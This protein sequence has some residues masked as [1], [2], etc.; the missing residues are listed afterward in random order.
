MA[1]CIHVSYISEKN[2]KEKDPRNPPPKQRSETFS[3]FEEVE[4]H[5]CFKPWIIPN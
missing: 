4:R 5:L 1:Y 2:I 3:N